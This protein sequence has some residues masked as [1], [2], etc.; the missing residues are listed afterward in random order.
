MQYAVVSLRKHS[1]VGRELIHLF[2]VV[3][4][5][6]QHGQLENLVRYAASSGMVYRVSDNGLQHFN[7]RL[8][9]SRRAVIY[10]GESPMDW[11]YVQG[12]TLISQVEDTENLQLINTKSEHFAVAVVCA[13]TTKD[14]TPQPDLFGKEQ[15]IGLPRCSDHGLGLALRQP[16]KIAKY[17]RDPQY[18]SLREA[19]EQ[20]EYKDNLSPLIELLTI[21]RFAI[22]RPSVSTMF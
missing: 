12:S 22:I 14:P 13:A 2:S 4:R 8:S 15:S 10:S 18:R 7:G 20:S 21:Q 1:A 11:N 3:P 19:L 9:I 17:R 5:R 6:A 16:R